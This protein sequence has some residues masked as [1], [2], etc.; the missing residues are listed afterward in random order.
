M[1]TSSVNLLGQVVTVTANVSADPTSNK[2]M[3][4]LQAVLF[5]NYGLIYL[6]GSYAP[7]QVTLQLQDTNNPQLTALSVVG[8]VGDALAASIGDAGSNIQANLPTSAAFGGPL[9]STSTFPPGGALTGVP[10]GGAS[11][12]GGFGLLQTIQSALAGAWSAVNSI[13]KS[14]FSDLQTGAIVVLVAVAIIA[15]LIVAAKS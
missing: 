11:T 6:G 15:V 8:A 1:S 3:G 5:Q 2:N 4:A 14:L 13:L 10:G 7:P 12:V 9:V